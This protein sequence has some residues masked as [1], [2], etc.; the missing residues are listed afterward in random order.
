MVRSSC[1]RFSCNRFIRSRNLVRVRAVVA[2]CWRKLAMW[3]YSP[4]GEPISGVTPMPEGQR[5]ESLLEKPWGLLL[6]VQRG[7]QEYQGSVPVDCDFVQGI[8]RL[9][10]FVHPHGWLPGQGR[11]NAIPGM[12]VGSAG[13]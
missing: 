2:I 9:I 11:G 12:R 7:Q 3:D 1:G 5:G 10:I 4:R 8:R 6:R 13:K